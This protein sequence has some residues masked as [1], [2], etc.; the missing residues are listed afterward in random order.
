MRVFRSRRNTFIIVILLIILGSA[1]YISTRDPGPPVDPEVEHEVELFFSTEDA[2]Y[3]QSETRTVAGEDFYLNV[4]QELIAGP[5][6]EELNPTIPEDSE[7]LGVEHERQEERLIIN[8]N[9]NW[10]LDHWG[11]STGERLT[12]YSIVNTMTSLPEISR[13]RFLVEGRE[14]ESLAGHLDL[15]TDYSFSEDIVQTEK[16]RE[17][18]EEEYEVEVKEQEEEENSD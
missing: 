5:Q 1:L 18:N 4:L 7:V 6:S 10:R 15:T 11:G 12:I 16:A 13:V 2:M 8:F 14:I 17:I 9:D 3:L